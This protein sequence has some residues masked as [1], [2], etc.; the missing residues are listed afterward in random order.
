MV[1]AVRTQVLSQV[2]N[3]LGKQGNLYLSRPRIDFVALILLDDFGFS[4]CREHPA[5]LGLS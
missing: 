2:I 1:F 3:L 5:A 4:L